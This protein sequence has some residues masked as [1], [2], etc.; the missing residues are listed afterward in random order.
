MKLNFKLITPLSIFEPP[1]AS[2][3]DGM[4]SNIET[5]NPPRKLSGQVSSSFFGVDK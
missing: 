4:C 3:S 2:K 5:N 1:A